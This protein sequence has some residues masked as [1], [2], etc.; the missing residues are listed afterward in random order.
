MSPFKGDDLGQGF[1]LFAEM[2]LLLEIM[3]F[4]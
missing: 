4:M 2:E 1:V 3:S